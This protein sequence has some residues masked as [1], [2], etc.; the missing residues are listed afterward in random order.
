MS[1]PQGNW[2][3]ALSSSAVTARSVEHCNSI[4]IGQ[5]PHQS[6]DKG[7]NSIILKNFLGVL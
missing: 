7:S 1:A 2:A 4:S 5:L 6:E 3:S